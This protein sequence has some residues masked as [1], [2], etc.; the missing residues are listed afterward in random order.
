MKRNWFV[1]CGAL[2]LALLGVVSIG[3][4]DLVGLWRFDNPGNL[5]QDGAFNGNDLI[6]QGGVSFTA[7]GKYGGAADFNGT[8][9]ALGPSGAFP[10]DVP[11][12]DSSYTIAAWFLPDQTGDR[13]IVGWGNYG[14]GSQVNALRT[15]GTNGFRHY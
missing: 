10:N 9:G 3:R 12:G 6:V 5:G 15:F 2:S 8:D 11:I 13:G 1:F 7:S 14:T 4:A